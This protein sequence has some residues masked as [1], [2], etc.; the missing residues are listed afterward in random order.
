MDR[1]ET[2]LLPR[3]SCLHQLRE[4]CVSFVTLLQLLCGRPTRS[5]Q[6]HSTFTSRCCRSQWSSGSTC[7]RREIRGSNRVVD[8]SLCFSRKSLRYAALG[9]GCTLI[10]VPRLTQPSTLR[11]TLNEYLPHGCVI[12]PMVMGECSA[13]SSLQANSK[14]KFAAWPTS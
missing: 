6:S 9:M 8:K 14:V 7:L 11:G 13:Y 5:F 12:I 3:T 2:R 10:A 1:H 4:V